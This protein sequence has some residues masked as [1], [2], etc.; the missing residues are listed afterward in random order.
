VTEDA[1]ADDHGGAYALV[2]ASPDFEHHC[3]GV[4]SRVAAVTDGTI[5]NGLANKA[6]ACSSLRKAGRQTRS[7]RLRPPSSGWLSRAAGHSLSAFLDRD[8]DT[9]D[10]RDNWPAHSRPVVDPPRQLRLFPSA[11]AGAPRAGDG[12]SWPWLCGGG[13]VFPAGRA[14][15]PASFRLAR[16]RRIEND[17]SS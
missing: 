8:T 7:L 12:S 1:T 9:A 13:L 3:A 11:R 4:Q 5:G 14:A 10:F 16:S 2:A 6:I 15:W 17:P